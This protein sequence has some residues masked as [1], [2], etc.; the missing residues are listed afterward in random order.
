[1]KR[2]LHLVPVKIII[3][4]YLKSSYNWF[5]SD[6]PRLVQQLTTIFSPD[7]SHLNYCTH[8]I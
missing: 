3:L 2:I 5:E 4:L 6:I 1:M 8:I 7:Q